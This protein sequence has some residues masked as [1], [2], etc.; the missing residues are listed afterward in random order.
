MFRYDRGRTGCY[1]F[2][3]PTGVEGENGATPSLTRIS[4][5]YPNP[6]NPST[7][8]AF[9]LRTR[10]RVEVAVYDVSGRKVAVLAA[11]VMEAGRHEA[12]WHGRT[13]SG[14]VAASGVYFCT[15]RADGVVETKKMVLLR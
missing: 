15:L 5:I 4:S 11:G 7:R 8:I 6:F 13:L 10:G 2:V 1:G 9:D 12:A 14:G 3:V